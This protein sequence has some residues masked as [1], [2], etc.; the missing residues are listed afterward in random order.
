MRSHT[1]VNAKFYEKSYE[2]K[3]DTRR[4]KENY[5]PLAVENELHDCAVVFIHHFS[6]SLNS[7]SLNDRR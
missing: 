5:V 2:T 6:P 7:Y 3:R 1:F 4:R